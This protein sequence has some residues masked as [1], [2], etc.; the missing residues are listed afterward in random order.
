M[1]L[2]LSAVVLS[3]FSA[4]PAAP[5]WYKGN[6]HT[7][8]DRSDGD[9]PPE[10]V[11]EWYRSHGYHFVVITD[12]NRT[13]SV[14]ALNRKYGAAN[15]FLVIVGNEITC[16]SEGKP[17]HLTALNV[18]GKLFPWSMRTR[19]ETLAENIGRICAAGATPVICHPNDGWALDV[20]TLAKVERCGLLEV[21]NRH[22]EVNNA[23]GGGLPGTEAMWDSLLTRGKRY[24]GVA[25]D[26][27][28]HL[29]D[30]S[31]GAAGPGRGWVS[32]RCGKLTPEEI[33]KAMERGDF[34]AS[35][36]VELRDIRYDGKVL[37]LSVR[38]GGPVRYT[39]EFIG[40]NGRVMEKRN[41]PEC[42]YR[43]TG[44][45]RYIRARVTD[46][47]GLQ[48]WTQPIFP[49]SGRPQPYSP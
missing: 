22:P 35:T 46:S 19:G 47:N 29:G 48:A 26:D 40:E 38:K 1:K 39:V 49:W 28:H 12:H 10:E 24:Y 36:G 7:H 13:A 44:E 42:E 33:A 2:I 21:W 16:R 25:C 34:Y 27:L 3:L 32:V 41:N 37:R 23:G 17:V 5:D 30:T 6:T 15:R 9:S 18:L 20:D 8:T 31:P 45:E 14:E 11:V 43:F 4:A